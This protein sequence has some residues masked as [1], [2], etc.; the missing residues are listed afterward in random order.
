MSSFEERKEGR[1][2]RIGTFL[3]L[4]E[5]AIEKNR[6]GLGFLSGVI[7][8]NPDRVRIG[9]EN[10]IIL[11]NLA[12]Y[13]IS[14]EGLIGIFTNPYTIRGSGMPRVEVH[15]KGRWVR[16]EQKACIQSNSDLD[17]PATDSL[18]TLILGLLDDRNLFLED[19]Q[20]PLRAALMRTYGLLQSPIADAVNERVKGK[21]GAAFNADLGEFEIPGTDG[22]TWHIECGDPETKSYR[23]TSRYRD[24]PRRTHAEDTWDHFSSCKD[25][26]WLMGELCTAPRSFLNGKSA[27]GGSEKFLGS[28]SEFFAPLRRSLI[29]QR[30]VASGEDFE[31]LGDLFG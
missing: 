23:I 25:L 22:F 6:V 12:S 19:N 13:C 16:N 27:M 5:R 20:D 10:L 2:E 7:K 11:G 3:S 31:G 24:G 14:L 18:A 26:D 17:K 1:K 15:P 30:D 29:E 4:F 8:D 9:H 28:V 21:Y